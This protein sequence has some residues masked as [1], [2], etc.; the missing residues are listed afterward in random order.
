MKFTEKYKIIKEGMAD[1]PR[2]DAERLRHAIEGELDAINLY[3]QLAAETKNKDVSK[4]LLDISKEEKIHV[5]E[6]E[7]V[8]NMIDKEQI[9]ADKDGESEVEKTLKK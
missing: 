6:L 3:D 4:V 5:S 2:T 9:V 8:L 7:T 1:R